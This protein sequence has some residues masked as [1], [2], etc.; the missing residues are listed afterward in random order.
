MHTHTLTLVAVTDWAPPMCHHCAQHFINVILTT[1][2]GVETASPV[3]Q[4]RKGKHRDIKQFAQDHTAVSG[5]AKI[6]T[7]VF[8]TPK[9]RS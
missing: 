6:C 5:T 8:E 9:S 4:M 7:R 3:L 2:R 1:H